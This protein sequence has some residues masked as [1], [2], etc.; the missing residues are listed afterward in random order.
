MS[1]TWKN[2][3]SFTYC[4]KYKRSE[5]IVFYNFFFLLVDNLSADFTIFRNVS[6]LT[7]SFNCSY[8]LIKCCQ[9]LVY[10]TSYIYICLIIHIA[11][12]NLLELRRFRSSVLYYVMWLISSSARII[13]YSK[14][15][16][17]T[18]FIIRM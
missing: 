3:I 4:A 9:Y 5:H 14:K 15:Y 17:D 1:D 11:V 12:Y 13:N 2:L 6:I 7:I 16:V 18:V 8:Y 10:F